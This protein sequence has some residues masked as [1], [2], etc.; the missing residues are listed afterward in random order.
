MVQSLL[1]GYNHFLQL[2]V[3]MLTV[4]QAERGVINKGDEVEIIGYGD[5]LKTTVTSVGES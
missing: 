5:K 2:Y 4:A 3:P 1:A